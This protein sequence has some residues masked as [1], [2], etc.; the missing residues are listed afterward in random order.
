M[1]EHPDSEPAVYRLVTIGG[2]QIWVDPQKIDLTLYK[3][4]RYRL[5]RRRRFDDEPPSKGAA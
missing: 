3:R 2:K 5:A 1:T 4:R